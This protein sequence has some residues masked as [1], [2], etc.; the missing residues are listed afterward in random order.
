MFLLMMIVFFVDDVLVD[1]VIVDTVL[2]DGFLVDNVLVADDV[3][4]VDNVLVD[5]DDHF[6]YF[7]SILGSVPL[8]Y[9]TIKVK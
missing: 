6:F 1:D 3:V 9:C 7:C 4:L 5:N 8:H 2:V